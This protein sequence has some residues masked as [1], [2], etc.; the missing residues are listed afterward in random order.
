MA[1]SFGIIEL[2]PFVSVSPDLFLEKR[3][4]PGDASKGPVVSSGKNTFV[5]LPVGHIGQR[6]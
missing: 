6:F 4:N 1:N 2:F 3:A 5:A